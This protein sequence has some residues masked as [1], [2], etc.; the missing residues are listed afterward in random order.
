MRVNHSQKRDDLEEDNT[1]MLRREILSYK[2]KGVK[3]QG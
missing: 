1:T 2:I 3:S